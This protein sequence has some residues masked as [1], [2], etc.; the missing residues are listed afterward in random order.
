MPMPRRDLTEGAC[1]PPSA[2]KAMVVL[3]FVVL[4]R[5]SCG[6]EETKPEPSLII[7]YHVHAFG[8]TSTSAQRRLGRTSTA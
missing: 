1:M 6:C 2:M 3:T 8:A 7:S 4:F 5:S